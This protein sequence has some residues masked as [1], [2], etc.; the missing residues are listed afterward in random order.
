MNIGEKL[1]PFKLPATN[2]TMYSSFDFADKHAFLIIVTCNHCK[3]ARAYWQR[4]INLCKKYEED[5]LAVV[6]INGN[7]AAQYPEDSLEGMQRM[8]SQLGLPFP[9]LHDERQEYL[10]ILGATRTPEVFLFN[11]R[12]ELVYHGAID[13]SWD[14][15][16]AVM[17]VYL[18]DAVEYCLDGLEVD[19]PEVQP[20]G[21]GIKWRNN[22]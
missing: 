4:L 21:C 15:E 3:Y 19:F 5:N 2:G 17:Q 10:K 11:S 6:A 12:R 7:D 18:E 14:N 20:V 22:A 1:V 16:H 13:D 9:Y 8:V